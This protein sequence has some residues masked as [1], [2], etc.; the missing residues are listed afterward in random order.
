MKIQVKTRFDCTATG[1]TGHYKSN[2]VPYQDSGDNLIEDEKSWTRSRNQQRNYETL[3]QLLSL[4]TQLT[5]IGNSEYS[6]GNWLFEI[7]SDRD[8]V[9]SDDFASLKLDCENVPMIINLNETQ[10]LEPRLRTQGSE[11][12]IWF[13]EI[14]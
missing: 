2:R 8:D 4:R 12:N 7:E 9:F 6:D 5:N 11:A 10:S 3:I 14:E 1:T 13:R